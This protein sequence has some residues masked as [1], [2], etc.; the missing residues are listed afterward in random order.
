M[1]SGGIEWC[2]ATW[3]PIVGCTHGCEFCYARRVMKRR[4][5]GVREDGTHYGCWNCWQFRPHLHEERLGQPAAVKSP[6]II[7]CGSVTDLFDPG[8]GYEGA[9]ELVWGAMER[10]D[11]HHYVALTK[12]PDLIEP[13]EL[14]DH[15]RT[16][17]LWL[18]VSV[19]CDDDWWR[20]ERLVEATRHTRV[21]PIISCEPLLGP[22]RHEIPREIEWV[23]V[24]AQTGAG[25]AECR[26]SWVE[27]IEEQVVPSHREGPVL[28]EK[29]NLRELLGVPPVQHWPIWMMQETGGVA[30]RG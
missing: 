10:A 28:F 8:V 22:I 26:L 17:R 21:H 13:A 1:N 2:D 29:D 24:G 4:K 15:A 6:R 12:R 18:G 11:W 14:D 9:R 25:A 7:F 3:N 19:T 23:I 20:V 30:A 27:D 5:P 16:L